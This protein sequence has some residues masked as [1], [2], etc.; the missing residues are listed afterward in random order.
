MHVNNVCLLNCYD[1]DDD[2]GSL[3]SIR[4]SRPV[5]LNRV[6]DGASYSG[7]TKSFVVLLTVQ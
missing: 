2:D 3:V 1:D 7:V 4:S 5:T 6:L